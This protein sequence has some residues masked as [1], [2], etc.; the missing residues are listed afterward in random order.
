MPQR[1]TIR[2]DSLVTLSIG[3][4][5]GVYEVVAKL[6]QGGMGEVY[7]ARDTR[8]ERD[9]AI[10]V[11]P[12]SVAGDA[13][14]IMRFEREAKTLAALN[15]PHIAHIHG[16]E[17]SGA[18][19]AL[20]MELVEG[21][22]LAQRLARGAIPLDE[23]LAIAEQIADALQAAHAAGIVHR[24]LKPANV[25]L[26]PDGTI[27][28]LDFGL[29]KAGGSTGAGDE[30]LLNSPTFT[31]PVLTMQGVILGT[32]AYMSP[33]QA[34]GRPVDS[35]ADIWAFGC[36][37]YEMLTGRRAF[38]GD[39]L[40]ET[41]AA[42]VKQQPDR[43]GV[44]ATCRRLIDACL[45]KDP[46]K[47]LQSIGDVRHLIED[48]STTAA[49]GARHSTGPLMRALAA[50]AA[51]STIGLAGLAF[52]H[53]RE[54]PPPGRSMQLSVG[55]PEGAY[56]GFV[57]IAPDGSRLTLNFAESGGR[58]QIHVR[59]IDSGQL[60]PLTGSTM[61]RTP[62]WSPDS[63]F[64]AFFA[65]DT[66]KV[67]PASGGPAQVPCAGVRTGLGRGGSWSRDGVLLFVT[68]GGE[69]MRGDASG[70]EC[71]QL[72]SATRQYAFPVFLPDGRHFFHLGRDRSGAEAGVYLASLEDPVGRRL[73]GDQSSVV[74]APRTATAGAHLLFLRESTLMGQ[75]F[76]DERLQLV[77]DPFPIASPVSQSASPPQVA[78]SAATDG[79]LVFVAGSEDTQLTWLDRRGAVVGTV[80]APGRHYGVIM[81]PDAKS[82][83]TERETPGASA[84][85]WLYDLDRGPGSRVAAAGA[86]SSGVWSSDSRRLWFPTDVGQGRGWYQRDFSTGAIE[87]LQAEEG[88]PE[89]VPSDWSSDGR[90]MICTRVDPKSG[91]DIWSVPVQS[92]AP[93]FKNA[94]RFVTSAAAES[95]GQLSPDGKWLAYTSDESG[96][97]Q[98]HLRSFPDGRRVMRASIERGF[99]PRWRADGQELFFVM[100]R[101]GEVQLMAVSI[102]ADAQGGLQVGVPQKLFETRVRLSMI[103]NN[104]LSYA[105]HPDGQRFLVN[106]MA[107]TAER[108]VTVVTNWL[109]LTA[110]AGRQSR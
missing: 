3:S 104:S 67:M 9:V 97:E 48:P 24:D 82:V 61:A 90:F 70:G 16:I 45:Q 78:A 96:L 85:F 63:R 54:T 18:T 91:P 107:Q 47:R 76:D 99:E 37:L 14:R 29:A 94:V 5:I 21:E 10:K 22:D 11:L 105:P 65:D 74:Y 50:V 17:D 103:Q 15:H 89:C 6:G 60:Q 79:T 93:D 56:V 72:G 102:K 66:L 98:V 86:D 19:R 28:V 75:A 62:F 41:L 44:P 39:D 7:R 33:E 34:R 101:M 42:V 88:K 57:T 30:D 64:L 8:L 69:L 95:Q 31:S 27:K 73:L 77:G 23:S 108:T 26:R 13:D 81:S 83:V 38:H 32:A 4:R 59:A 68:D 20:V 35:R 92:G 36:V 46:K 109:A 2:A 80:G 106:V 40:T 55:V 84:D 71:R 100:G 87:R 49:A 52:V 51:L 110:Q 53:F 1:A 43:N 12:A 58:P 25:K